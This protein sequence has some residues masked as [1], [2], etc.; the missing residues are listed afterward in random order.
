MESAD[1]EAE[2]ALL[3]EHLS[4]EIYGAAI[5]CEPPPLRLSTT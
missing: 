2:P 5:S 3:P 4:K 1:S